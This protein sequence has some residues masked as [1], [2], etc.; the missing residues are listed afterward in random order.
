MRIESIDPDLA[1]GWLA[2]PWESSLPVS[3]G[4]ATRA[5]DDP[6]VHARVTE[7]FLVARGAVS[8]RVERQ[9][10]DLRAGDV[11]F[12]EPG[13]PHTILDGSDDLRLFVLHVPG[14]SGEEAAADR[15]AVPRAVLGL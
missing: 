5:I 15:S 13:E 14:V 2:G 9:T 8:M 3:V 4:F 12:V 7:I 11:L 6:H 10:V 1:K